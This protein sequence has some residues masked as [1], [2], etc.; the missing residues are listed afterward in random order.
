MP[1]CP[2]VIRRLKQPPHFQRPKEGPTVFCLVSSG[3]CGRTVTPGAPAQG[4]DAG[5]RGGFQPRGL[6]GDRAQLP[7]RCTPVPSCL[8]S[9]S[10]HSSTAGGHHGAH[11]MPWRRERPSPTFPTHCLHPQP[12]VRVGRLQGPPKTLVGVEW[13]SVVLTFPTRV[14]SLVKVP[15]YK[16][17]SSERRIPGP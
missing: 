2:P 12:W 16:E 15:S 14:R 3:P 11:R 4:T 13:V 6:S 7:A 17:S 1:Q 5:R 8:P 10:N 9:G